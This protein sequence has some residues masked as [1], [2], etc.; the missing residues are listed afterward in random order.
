SAWILARSPSMGIVRN[1]SCNFSTSSTKCIWS[2]RSSTTIFFG[3]GS[4]LEQFVDAVHRQA[5]ILVGRDPEQRNFARPAEFG[6]SRDDARPPLPAA[7]RS[8][9]LQCDRASHGGLDV[10]TD[11]R[12][13]ELKQRI[14][15][16]RQGPDGLLYVLTAEENGALLRIE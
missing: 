13:M 12:L 11:C 3:L 8:A 7:A 2:A 4:P 9:T 16:V 10:A 6:G 5:G 14:R 15:D 1:A